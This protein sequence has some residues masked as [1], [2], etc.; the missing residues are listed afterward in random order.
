MAPEFLSLLYQHVQSTIDLLR[1]SIPV[2]EDHMR[3]AS[4]GL[5]EAE[6]ELSRFIADYN[7]LERNH[8]ITDLE[9]ALRRECENA[10]VDMRTVTRAMEVQHKKYQKK[11]EEYERFL[12][13]LATI[14]LDSPVG[15]NN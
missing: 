7:V 12:E 13:F 10:V 11:L 4:E 8:E 3:F 15:Q 2:C 6:Q 9:R 14:L 1:K 5:A